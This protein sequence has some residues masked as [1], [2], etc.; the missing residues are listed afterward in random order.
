MGDALY[1]EIQSG[2]GFFES[3]NLVKGTNN[4]FTTSQLDCY[5][6]KRNSNE[7]KD[8]KMNVFVTY[9]FQG[10]S[11]ETLDKLTQPLMRKVSQHYSGFVEATILNTERGAYL[12]VPKSD[13]PTGIALKEIKVGE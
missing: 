8:L 10:L 4:F 13:L 12:L 9:T 7:L 11:N 3:E 1:D 5:A 2:E 6:S